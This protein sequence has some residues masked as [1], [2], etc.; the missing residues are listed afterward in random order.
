VTAA[1]YLI[2]VSGPDRAG[3]AAQ[4]FSAVHEIASEN[5]TIN[6]VAQITIRGYLVLCCEV[7]VDATE[8]PERLRERAAA[9]GMIAEGIDVTVAVVEPRDFANDKRLLVTFLAPSVTSEAFV[10]V[11]RAIATS[12]AT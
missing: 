2:T 9:T 1:T 11:F 7:T 6:D 5:C 10:A 3:V 8:T 4:L 12:G